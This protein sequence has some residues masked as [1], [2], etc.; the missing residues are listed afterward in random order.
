MKK[1]FWEQNWIPA[2]VVI[3][4]FFIVIEII[5]R[6]EVNEGIELQMNRLDH[7]IN[8]TNIEMNKTHVIMNIMKIET[9][10]HEESMNKK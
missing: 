3:T 7:K 2:C 1:S 8:L 5:C 9:K 10:R 4:F 6:T